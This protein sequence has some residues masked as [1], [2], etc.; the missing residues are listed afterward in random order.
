[1]TEQ[2]TKEREQRNKQIRKR[3][4]IETRIVRKV[5]RAGIK[6][7]YH[8]AVYDGEEFHPV[9]PERELMALLFNL[10]DAWL[11][12]YTEPKP[13]VLGEAP[14][15]WFARPTTHAKGWV[16]FVFGNDGWDVICDYT[17]NL[18]ELLEPIEQYCNEQ[19]E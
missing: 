1:M 11:E 12:F 15:A 6:A 16:R 4:A 14:K 5:I 19:T 10:D 17:T 8:L 7:G 18:S 3:I 13:K 9:M 2:D